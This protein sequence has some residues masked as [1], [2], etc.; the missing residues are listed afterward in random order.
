MTTYTFYMRYC[1]T[2][3]YRA[4]GLEY[5]EGSSREDAIVR[6]ARKHRLTVDTAEKDS[7]NVWFL[8]ADGGAVRYGVEERKTTATSREDERS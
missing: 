2:S 7:D 5:C 4:P 6:F 1:D 3:I 8:F